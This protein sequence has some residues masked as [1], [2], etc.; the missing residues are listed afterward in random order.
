M[1]MSS[2]EILTDI[3]S[4][5]EDIS[6]PFAWRDLY[7]GFVESSVTYQG[8]RPQLLQ[9]WNERRSHRV[10]DSLKVENY[11][12][13]IPFLKELFNWYF[14]KDLYGDYYSE[15]NIILS[16]GSVA[17][18]SFPLS[19][20]VKSMIGRSLDMDWYGYSDSCGRESCREAI[21]YW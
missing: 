11:P 13:F 18:S 12:A 17:Q 10:I 14:Q 15:Q 16:S 19:R 5:V 3:A 2:R 20:G 6:D 21:S 9:L 8:T 1:I 7:L 4:C